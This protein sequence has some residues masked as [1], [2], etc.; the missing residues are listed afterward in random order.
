MPCAAANRNTTTDTKHNQKEKTMPNNKTI[1]L[2]QADGNTA[3]YNVRWLIL[4]PRSLTLPLHEERLGWIKQTPAGA[5]LCDNTGGLKSKHDNTHQAIVAAFD[6]FGVA[7]T[8]RFQ[9]GE[10]YQVCTDGANIA[11]AD[12]RDKNGVVFVDCQDKHGNAVWRGEVAVEDRGDRE[13][14]TTNALAKHFPIDEPVIAG[15]NIVITADA[16][17]RTLGFVADIDKAARGE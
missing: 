16:T 8:R 3:P 4:H 9:F 13:V 6:A 7:D 11:I 17:K 10:V 2:R 1:I 12:N 14:I 5:N 15:D